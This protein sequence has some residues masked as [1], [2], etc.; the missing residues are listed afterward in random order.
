M[1]IV[2][3][4]EML[5]VEHRV[6]PTAT[7]GTAFGSGIVCVASVAHFLNHWQSLQIATT[8]PILLLVGYYWCVSSSAFH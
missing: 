4:V 5:D 3:V 6:A 7:S 8:L 1:E 2:S